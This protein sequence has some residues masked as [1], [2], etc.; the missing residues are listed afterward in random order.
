MEKRAN[1]E[2]EDYFEVNITHRSKGR[3]VV[4]KE[5]KE[6]ELPEEIGLDMSISG[7]DSKYVYKDVIKLMKL[8]YSINNI[9]GLAFKKY[10]DHIANLGFDN[11]EG[12]VTYENRVIKLQHKLEGIKFHMNK[13]IEHQNEVVKKFENEYELT[14]CI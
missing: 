3:T 7:R 5:G 8:L 14:I 11:V 13:F 4:W 1:K 12:I 10:N 6:Y 2:D 9:P